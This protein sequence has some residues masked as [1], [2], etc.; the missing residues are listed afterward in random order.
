LYQIGVPTVAASGIYAFSVSKPSLDMWH[1]RLGHPKKQRTLSVVNVEYLSTLNKIFNTC[2]AY[3]LGKL[4][5]LPSTGSFSDNEQPL[6]VIYSDVWGLNSTVSNK[7]YRYYIIFVDGYSRY[8]W[9]FPLTLKSK[10]FNAFIKFRKEI[11]KH[12]LQHQGITYKQWG[13]FS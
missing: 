11:E 8:T 7:G 4:H 2:N 6:S 3:Y 13:K 1:C 10:A 9:L 5:K 12:R